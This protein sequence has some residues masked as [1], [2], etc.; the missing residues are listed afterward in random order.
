MSSITFTIDGIKVQGSEGEYIIDVARRNGFEIPSLCHNE[1]LKPFGFC[2]VCV[3]EITSQGKTRILPS[4]THKIVDG[5][6]VVTTSEKILQQRR[7]RIETLLKRAP[8][9]LIL[10]KMA[11][12]VGATA[13]PPDKNADNCIQCGLCIRTCKEVVGAAALGFHK[14]D[15]TRVVGLVLHDGEPTCIGCGTCSFISMKDDGNTRTIWNITFTMRPCKSCGTQWIPEKQIE[16][17]CKITTTPPEFFDL[18][19]NCR[20]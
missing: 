5:M 14:R 2:R 8:D 10:H 17:I 6:E 12:E 19:L 7:E 15:D 9:A 16:H 20:T 4:C 1:A 11:A 3:V 13:P 18:C